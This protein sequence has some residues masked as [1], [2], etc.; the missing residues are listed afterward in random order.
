MVTLNLS[1]P[2]G[3]SM[4]YT[5][6]DGY[7]GARHSAFTK[8]H[9]GHEVAAVAAQ[10][11]EL[12]TVSALDVGT[13][14]DLVK[15]I[16]TQIDAAAKPRRICEDRAAAPKRGTHLDVELQPGET[17]TIRGR[18]HPD[19]DPLIVLHGR[20]VTDATEDDNPL[21][22]HLRLETRYAV[23]WREHV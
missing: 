15:A 16:T 10:V 19:Q 9:A 22:A 3:A 12:A 8:D 6:N 2:C 5:G 14:A 21:P 1:C 20:F 17:I 18:E 23:A 11:E 7:A 4:S 13:V